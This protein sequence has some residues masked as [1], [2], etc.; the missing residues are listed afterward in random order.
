MSLANGRV[1]SCLE[2]GYK[3]DAVGIGEC[4]AECASVLL[5][6]PLDNME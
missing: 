1:I 5:G 3:L 6:D 2:G 4:A